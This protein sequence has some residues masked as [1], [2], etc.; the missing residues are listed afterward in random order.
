MQEE[1]FL[2]L[3]GRRFVNLLLLI[4]V[5]FD[6]SEEVDFVTE[7]IWVVPAGTH[8]SIAVVINQFW[9]PIDRDVVFR[10]HDIVLVG[11]QEHA[12]YYVDL[13]CIFLLWQH[14]SRKP[15]R[16]NTTVAVGPLSTPR[17]VPSPKLNLEHIFVIKCSFGIDSG[18]LSDLRSRTVAI[19]F[20]QTEWL[21]QRAAEQPLD[22][23][24][25]KQAVGMRVFV[26]EV[27]EWLAFDKRALLCKYV[28]NIIF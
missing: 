19:L 15:V 16:A 10:F 24:V 6:D 11:Q 28:E 13:F 14:V 18:D 25:L 2:D 22:L 21:R 17:T 7:A 5:D 4:G 26:D 3:E 27:K 23:N 9:I 8:I 20:Y 12:N 1:T